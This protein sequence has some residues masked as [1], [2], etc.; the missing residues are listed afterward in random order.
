MTDLPLGY[1]GPPAGLLSEVLS[2]ALARG[3]ELAD[4]FVEQRQS[5]S[6]RLEDGKVEEALSG[7]DLGGSVRLVRGSATRF[8]YV[9]GVEE[10]DLFALADN[11]A[12]SSGDGDP[13]SSRE[14]AR[15]QSSARPYL[16]W[17]DP[18]DGGDDT[19]QASRQ[20]RRQDSLRTGFRDGE[21]A[22][23]L[24]PGRADT[25][26][27][28]QK[29]AGWLRIADEA[30]RA[31]SGEVR[32]VTAVYGES[33]QRVWVANSAGTNAADERA[34]KM[35]AIT[36]LAQRGSVIQMGRETLVLRDW[37]SE[38][39]EAAVV[40]AAQAAAQRALMMLDARPA[41]G[42]RMAVVLA[43]G[44]GGVLFHE[45]CGHGLEA[46][47]VLKNASVWADKIGHRVA[48][49]HVFA[50]D[51]GLAEGC[52]GS[53]STD[54]E[55]V[56]CQRT[57]VIEAGVLTGYLT[58]RLRAARL[59]LPLT[60]NGRRQDFRHLP[61]PRMTNTYFGPGSVKAEEL[62]AD[63]RYALYAKSLSGGQ[64]N[65]ATGEFVFGVAEGYL[66]ENGRI[67]SPVRG[68]TLIGSGV[69]VLKNIEAVADD[70]DIRPGTCGK[71][72]QLVPVGSGQPTLRIQEL[73]VGGTNV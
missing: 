57:T 53:A 6:L 60:G 43:N 36:A 37:E 56:P 44:F 2:R 5:L 48:G 23:E 34:R 58:D 8:G 10:G 26:A 30:A 63:T 59:G 15:Q 50:Y 45:A 13:G 16:G 70:L 38:F 40:T 3:G 1:S 66:I 69:E 19:R 51:D 68:A 4:I 39:D 71:E 24:S 22:P 64:V 32:Q 49:S 9:D 25:S 72:G 61:Y 20:D 55:G 47:Y 62:I 28:V 18:R 14:Y 73:T 12:R 27:H 65:P 42:G 67:T 54:D 7:S 29:A 33:W 31:M 17:T 11:L 41:P 46:D 21:R 52:W 35:L